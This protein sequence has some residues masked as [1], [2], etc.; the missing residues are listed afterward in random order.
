[1]PLN[2]F[3][4]KTRAGKKTKKDKTDTWLLTSKST[5][6]L[7]TPDCAVIGNGENED[8]DDQTALV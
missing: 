6:S 7:D 1:M 4:P 5:F 8:E 3:K 2:P